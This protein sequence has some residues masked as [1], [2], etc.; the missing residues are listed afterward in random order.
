MKVKGPLITLSA[1]VA[2]AVV[3]FALSVSARRG[4]PPPDPTAGAQQAATVAPTGTPA[5]TA[6]TTP[7][8]PP[9]T[10]APD[11]P[12]DGTYAG[13]VDG[14]GGSMAIA[15]EDGKAIAYLCDGKRVEAWMQ[16]TATG[17]QLTLS[18]KNGTGTVTLDATK[19]T[20]TVSAGGRTWTFTVKPV[21]APS[22]L[23]RSTATVR[24]AQA[25]GG[26]IVLPDGTQ[27]GILSVG[28]QPTEA[29]P[30]NTGTRTATVDGITLTAVPVTGT[31]PGGGN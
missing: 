6:T 29:P 8:V 10:K 2:V 7:E 1:G 31:P 9:T 21:A 25:V 26:W 18:G 28:G 3:L 30:L 15:M 19:A 27:V 14:G 12:T 5:A 13:G 22:G 11:G 4:D 23:Y 20:G 24:S 16:G 17:G